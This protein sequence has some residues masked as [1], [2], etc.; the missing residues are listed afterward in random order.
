MYLGTVCPVMSSACLV[1]PKCSDVSDLLCHM[2]LLPSLAS[3]QARTGAS[4]PWLKTSKTMNKNKVFFS[5][6]HVSKLSG[7]AVKSLLTNFLT[8]FFFYKIIEPCVLYKVFSLHLKFMEARDIFLLR[9]IIIFVISV[10][11]KFYLKLI[12]MSCLK[13]ELK[14]SLLSVCTP[15][16]TSTVN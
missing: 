5:L 9:N 15:Y 7:T 1:I 16:C 13:N 12:S 4:W 8:F 3:L 10:R 11:L 14:F 6:H 2:F